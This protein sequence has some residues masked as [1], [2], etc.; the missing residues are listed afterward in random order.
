MST[1]PEAK[2]AA[3]AEIAYQVIIMSTDYDCWHDS[4]D[5]SVEMVMGHMRANAVNARR[6]IAAV[7]DELSKEEHAELVQGKHL[8]GGRKFGI[9]TYPEG[10]SKKAVEKL[11]WLFEGYF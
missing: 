9:S 2:L 1:L 10:R 7:L 8:A 11:N 5:V 4:G 3:E 6:F